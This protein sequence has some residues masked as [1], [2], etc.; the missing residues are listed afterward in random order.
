VIKGR[1]YS[2]IDYCPDLGESGFM[3][4][5]AVGDAAKQADDKAKPKRGAPMNNLSRKGS[6]KVRKCQTTISYLDVDGHVLK[7]R[8][9]CPIDHHM[10]SGESA[11]GTR[12]GP[13]INARHSRN[14]MTVQELWPIDPALETY[15]TNGP[16]D[17]V[18]P[19]SNAVPFNYLPATL[20]I[21]PV[22]QANSTEVNPPPWIA[23]VFRRLDSMEQRMANPPLPPAM[24]DTM[25]SNHTNPL[26]P[27][28]ASFHSD[29]TLKL[30]DAIP[31]GVQAE[32]SNI[33]PR[34]ISRAM[35]PTEIHRQAKNKS[36]TGG[37]LPTTEA[38]QLPPA[39]VPGPRRPRTWPTNVTPCQTRQKAKER[40]AVTVPLIDSFTETQGKTGEVLHEM[41]QET[42][43][44]TFQP[45]QTR[46]QAK[47]KDVII[48]LIPDPLALLPTTGLSGQSRKRSATAQP[49]LP[50]PDKKKG[51]T[52]SSSTGKPNEGTVPRPRPL[53]KGTGV[54]R[55][56]D[57][58]DAFI[59][60]K[61]PKNRL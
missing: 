48:P 52:A 24:V 46:Q 35:H 14:S 11:L 9:Y 50:A 13:A 40:G 56:G 31:H 15:P 38:A 12:D 44:S 58:S 28:P 5:P 61:R 59:M 53:K 36:D 3:N 8:A 33:H 7:G 54:I 34:E 16:N 22:I 39:T 42:L 2:P 26:M 23:E 47:G 45:R 6:R 57:V 55:A 20:S 51:K 18:P 21:P 27:P 29:T 19:G 10:S 37:L 60:R 49:Q 43:P 4:S 41:K 25:A 17:P 1:A 30:T 32:E